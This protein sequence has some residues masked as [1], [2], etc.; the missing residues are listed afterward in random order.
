MERGTQIVYE[1]EG[2]REEGF[3]T[4]DAREPSAVWC[5]YWLDGE[6]DVLRTRSCS[7]LTPVRSLTIKDTRPQEL[8]DRKLD[9]I[10]YTRCQKCNR[11]CRTAFPACQR[12]A[13]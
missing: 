7:E 3:V 6:W 8:V 13:L 5:R 10:G 2:K 12:E 11:D 9:E 4:S 1:T